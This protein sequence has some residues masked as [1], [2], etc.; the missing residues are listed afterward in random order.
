[1]RKSF[2]IICIKCGKLVIN[3][4]TSKQKYCPECS[5]IENAKRKC[6]WQK[7]NPVPK[8]DLQKAAATARIKERILIGKEK[9]THNAFSIGDCVPNP[10]LHTLVRFA[11]P[12]NW[13]LSK[14]A[15]LNLAYANKGH[16]FIRREVRDLRNDIAWRVKEA[17]ANIPI[18]QGKVW[19]DLCVEKPHNKGDAINVLDT[20]C[21]AIKVGLGIDD[22]W[23]AIRWLDWSIVKDNPK[24]I[25]GISQ[26][27][28]EHHQICSYCG[29]CLPVREFVK[30]KSN[31]YGCGTECRECHRRTRSAVTQADHIPV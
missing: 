25:I 29:R 16:V 9:S 30:N 26:E 21:D 5:A 15:V 3:A 27:V 24:I 31:K 1:M 28:E 2:N 22:K 18:Y 17:F 14:N 4:W 7:I 6:Q 10:N 8:T 12:F 11:M 13:K 23:F 20:V 19:I